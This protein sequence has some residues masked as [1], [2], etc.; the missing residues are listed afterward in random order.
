MTFQINLAKLYNLSHL[1]QCSKLTLLQYVLI[2]TVYVISY[3]LVLYFYLSAMEN[4]VHTQT[5]INISLHAYY[6]YVDG[7]KKNEL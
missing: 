5:I 1:N 6:N 3:I 7:E 4:T 2:D